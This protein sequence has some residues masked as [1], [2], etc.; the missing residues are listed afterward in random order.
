MASK[1]PLKA[2]VISQQDSDW[3]VKEKLQAWQEAMLEEIKVLR[4][5]RDLLNEHLNDHDEGLE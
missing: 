3:R 5:C 2:A 1:D 4:D